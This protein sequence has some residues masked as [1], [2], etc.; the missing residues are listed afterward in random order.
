MKRPYTVLL[1]CASMAVGCA[2]IQDRRIEARQRRM[3]RSAYAVSPGACNGHAHSVDYAQGFEE[4][5]Y[6]VASGGDGCPPALPPQ[7]YWRATYNSPLG[8]EHVKAWTQ[9]VR[10]GAA[11]AKADRV[12]S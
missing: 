2:Q 4:G 7:K 8:Q 12:S 1:L 11:A 5:Y 6:D 9:G 3:A 10:D